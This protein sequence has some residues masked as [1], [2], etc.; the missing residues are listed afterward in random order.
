MAPVI[1]P[2]MIPRI[3]LNS[4]SICISPRNGRLDFGASLTDS[5]EL[6][7]GSTF[8]HHMSAPISALVRRSVIRSADPTRT[9]GWS[10]APIARM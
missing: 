5:G 4:C 8:A 10:S 2:T 7:V 1:T 3:A 9:C 6:R